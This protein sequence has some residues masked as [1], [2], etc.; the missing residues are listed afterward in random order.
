MPT[1]PHGQ[2]HTGTY[3]LFDDP[4]E[5]AQTTAIE[6]AN[7]IHRLEG[8]IRRQERSD[9]RLDH[10]REKAAK[11]AASGK[12][13]KSKTS[14]LFSRVFGGGGKS[15]GSTHESARLLRNDDEN[16]EVE[17]KARRPEYEIVRRP[18][19]PEMVYHAQDVDTSVNSPWLSE[20]GMVKVKSDDIDGFHIVSK[21]DI[22]KSG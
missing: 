5:L 4:D 16:E 7:E 2:A 8:Q 19:T 17:K 15:S 20:C 1:D 10:K 14:S 18:V 11:R 22:E 13:P 6:E 12:A 9:R 3:G 21:K